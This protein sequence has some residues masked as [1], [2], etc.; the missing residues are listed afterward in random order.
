MAPAV[1]TQAKPSAH[2][3]ELHESAIIIDGMNNSQMT[4]EYFDKLRRAGITCTMHP[5]AISTPFRQAIRQLCDFLNLVDQ[6]RDKVLIVRKADDVLQA[7][8]EGKV[9]M[10]MVLEDTRQIEDDIDLIRIF[11]ELGIRRMQL[12]YTTQNSVSCGKGDRPGHDSGLSA[13]GVRVV[14][15][16][17]QVGM[18][19]DLCHCSPRTLREAYEVVKKPAVLSHINVKGVYAHPG[20][21]T[22]E[23]L[24]M[25][26]KNGG[27]IGISGAPFYVKD[28]T[29]TVDDII[30]HIDYVKRKVGVDTVGVGL[31]IFE[32]HP[33]EFYHQFNLPEDRYGK[34]PWTWPKGI[35]TIERFPVI[36]EKL[37]ERGYTDA[38]VK[39]VMGENFLRVFRQVWG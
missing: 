15:K 26:K 29:P 1:A 9:G 31:A 8:R 18:L 19:I 21:L 14:Q 3:R 38:E 7:K 10:V 27:V 13:F 12:N 16:M 17:E 2:A 36:M 33:P 39:K 35:E 20:N 24:E 6:N 23:E 5:V 22:D 11:H 32:G 25:A 28:R 30:G 34:P 37:L 4:G